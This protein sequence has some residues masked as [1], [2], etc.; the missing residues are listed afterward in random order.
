MTDKQYLQAVGALPASRK[1]KISYAVS[2][3]VPKEEA[4]LKGD[5]EAKFYDSLVEQAK[6]HEKKYGFWPTFELEEIETDDPV[7]DIYG[8]Q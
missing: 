3:K 1:N 4:G 6:A 2:A 7:L 5:V 8:D